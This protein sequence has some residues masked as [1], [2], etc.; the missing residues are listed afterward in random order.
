MESKKYLKTEATDALL[1][2][3]QFAVSLRKEKRTQII[4][5]KRKKF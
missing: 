4:E 3:E 1:K 2:I 5:A